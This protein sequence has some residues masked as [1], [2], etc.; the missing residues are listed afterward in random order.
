MLIKTKQR[1]LD[2]FGRSTL[3]LQFLKV[4]YT[5]SDGLTLKINQLQIFCP[6]PHVS[7]LLYHWRK[8]QGITT[9][10]YLLGTINVCTRQITWQSITQLLGPKCQAGILTLLFPHSNLPQKISPLPRRNKKQQKKLTINCEKR[11]STAYQLRDEHV[12]DKQLFTAPL[13]Y[14]VSP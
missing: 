14:L 8:S 2:F 3:N 13:V 7:I 11:L 10:I 12:E 1:R 9:V 4:F 6:E 5:D